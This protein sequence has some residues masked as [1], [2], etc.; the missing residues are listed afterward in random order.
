MELKRYKSQLYMYSTFENG[1]ANVS[2]VTSP[3][4]YKS[5]KNYSHVFT[6]ISDYISFQSNKMMLLDKIETRA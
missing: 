3:K 5:I 2:I 1:D 6:E 4:L